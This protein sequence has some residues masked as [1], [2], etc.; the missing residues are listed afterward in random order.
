MRNKAGNNKQRFSSPSPSLLISRIS[1]SIGPCIGMV[2]CTLSLFLFRYQFSSI[3]IV[4]LTPQ[5]PGYAFSPF[6][7]DNTS[8]TFV[9]T[10]NKDKMGKVN[11]CLV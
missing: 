7:T 4:D 11:A 1:I 2:F 6:L 10:N 5:S 8:F 9:S 3:L